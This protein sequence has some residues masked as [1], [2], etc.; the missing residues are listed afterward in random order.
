[1]KRQGEEAGGQGRFYSY[2]QSP[3]PNPQSPIPNPQSP[4]PNPQSPVPNPQSICTMLAEI[5][6]L[7]SQYQR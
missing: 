7:Q 3:I 2:A 6:I 5:N 1:M 4:I